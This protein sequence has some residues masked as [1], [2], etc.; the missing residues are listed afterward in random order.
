[1]KKIKDTVSKGFRNS[2]GVLE[3]GNFIDKLV[4]L[5]TVILFLIGIFIVIGLAV[6]VGYFLIKGALLTLP[7]ILCLAIIFAMNYTLTEDTNLG[8]ETGIILSRTK[9]NL[10]LISI[11]I[12]IGYFY[13]YLIIEI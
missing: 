4:A 5:V 12:L 3:E 11:L 8:K 9:A 13:K 2:K 6:F 7:V 1:M 10:I